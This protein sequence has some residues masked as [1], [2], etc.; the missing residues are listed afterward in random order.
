MKK[1]NLEEIIRPK[2]KEVSITAPI[3]IRVRGDDQLFELIVDGQEVGAVRGTCIQI[4]NVQ[5]E[6]EKAAF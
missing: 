5:A 3:K 4:L 6:Y 2:E 1:G